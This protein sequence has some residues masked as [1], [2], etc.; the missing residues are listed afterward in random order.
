MTRVIALTT[1]SRIVACCALRSSR[2]TAICV[3]GNQKRWKQLKIYVRALH[4]SPEWKWYFP[5]RLRRLVDP[6]NQLQRLP[7]C[8]A[9]RVGLR[10]AAQHRQH[11]PVVALMSEAIDV[12]R[13][14]FGCQ[15]QFVVVVVVRELPELDLVHSGA[16]DFYRAL[17]P[18]D[19]DRPLEVARIRQHRDFNRPERARAEF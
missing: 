19:R 1:E 9:V 10:L 13:I 3:C 17:L 18:E 15:N 16:A 6:E 11:V 8:A 4:L 2:G 7:P 14:G 12:G 5:P